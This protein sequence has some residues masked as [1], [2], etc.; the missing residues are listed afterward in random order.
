MSRGLTVNDYIEGRRKGWSH[1]RIA[2]EYGVSKQRVSQVSKMEA[3]QPF[4]PHRSV[5]RETYWPFGAIPYHFTHANQH[6]RLSDHLSYVTPDSELSKPALDRLRGFYKRLIDNDEV[7]EYDPD[8]PPSEDNVYGGWAYRPR[9][10]ADGD[11]IIRENQYTRPLYPA[12][13]V[14]WRIPKTLP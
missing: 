13:R 4:R 7:V 3:A 10:P 12:D 8:I 5:L 11:L 14:I 9:I 1:Q 2:E 6:K